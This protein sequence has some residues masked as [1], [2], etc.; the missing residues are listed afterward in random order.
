MPV[1][2]LIQCFRPRQ[3]TKNILL[4]AALVFSHHVHQPGYLFRSFAA[5]VLFS[6]VSGAVYVVNDIFDIGRDRLHPL[7]KKRP[8]ASGAV[9]VAAALA[10]AL[11]VTAVAATASDRKC[12]V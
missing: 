2:K 8:I 1:L 4:F 7:K 3:W 6:L 11:P 12:V 10:A 5:F 9:P